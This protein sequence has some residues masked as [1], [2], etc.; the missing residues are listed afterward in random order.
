MS[1]NPNQQQQARELNKDWAESILETGV[2]DGRI[3]QPVANMLS[4]DFALGN[5][6]PGEREYYRLLAENILLFVEEEHP[7]EDSLI[8][9]WL[10]AALLEDETQRR[11]ALS[12]RKK[13]ELESILLDAHSRTSRG[14]EGWQQDQF[15]K[16][17][18]VQ[19]VEDDRQQEEESGLSGLF[20]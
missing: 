9:G 2:P 13:T 20:S 10:G 19:R 1:S 6:D 17:T 3:P 15:S 4:D 12:Q 8:Q 14:I 18:S 5:L 7:P 16:S 11:A